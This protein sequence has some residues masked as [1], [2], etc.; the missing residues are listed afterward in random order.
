MACKNRSVFDDLNDALTR[1]WS[2]VIEFTYNYRLPKRP[3]LAILRKNKVLEDGPRG[4]TLIT[5]EQMNAIIELSNSNE[6]Y[7]VDQTTI[8]TPDHERF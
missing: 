5:R 6:R 2:I 7:F 3:N 1:G 4:P 8:R